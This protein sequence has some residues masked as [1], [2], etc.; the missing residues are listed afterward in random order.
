MFGSESVENDEGMIKG[1]ESGLVLLHL[2]RRSRMILMDPEFLIPV[3]PTNEKQTV[4]V[5]FG[6]HKGQ[7]FK[8]MKPSKESPSDF[9]LSP[10]ALHRRKAM[11]TINAENLARCDYRAQV[12]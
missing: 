7:V 5:L 11:V 1:I 10:Y 12:T 6:E 3:M 4:V 2:T 9:P 8:T